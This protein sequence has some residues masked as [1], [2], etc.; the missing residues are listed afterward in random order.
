MND[1]YRG[2]D[3]PAYLDEHARREF[4]RGLFGDADMDIRARALGFENAG[5]AQRQYNKAM[6]TQNDAI[7]A[8]MQATPGWVQPDMQGKDVD[9]VGSANYC[10]RMA[11]DE[12][13]KQRILGEVERA[14]MDGM[15][16]VCVRD[17]HIFEAHTALS[18]DE[19]RT[20]LAA[21]LAKLVPQAEG[22][23]P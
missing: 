23:E 4:N 19:R 20:A 7:A 18:A 22:L 21:V 5:D 14:P 15:I 17:G 13:E 11:V 6:A 2:P 12:N 9:E 10:G 3:D 16:V 1:I 8:S